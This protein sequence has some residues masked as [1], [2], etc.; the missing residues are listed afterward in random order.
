MVVLAAHAI[1]KSLNSPFFP[2]PSIGAELGRAKRESRITCMRM[3]R[4]PP[5]PA[6]KIKKK[7]GEKSYLE[8]ISRFGL[9]GDF[10]NKRHC[11]TTTL[12]RAA[13]RVWTLIDNDKLAH[14][15]AKLAAIMIKIK[16]LAH[17]RHVWHAY[18]LCLRLGPRNFWLVRSEH[19]HISYPGLPFR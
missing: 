3:L 10:L 1:V 13:C 18:R 5:I 9:W 16:F 17:A 15:I 12:T 11:A 7:M 19:V 8:V 6:A 2:T 14:Q 4:T